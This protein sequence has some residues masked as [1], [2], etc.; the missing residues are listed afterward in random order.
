MLLRQLPLLLF[1]RGVDETHKESTGHTNKTKTYL[2]R[3]RG[4]GSTPSL[5]DGVGPRANKGSQMTPVRVVLTTRVVGP[6]PQTRLWK[7]RPRGR[8]RTTGT[9][10]DPTGRNETFGW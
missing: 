7:S 10:V 4:T 2:G 8:T 9:D 6:T 1:Q 5:L 3:V